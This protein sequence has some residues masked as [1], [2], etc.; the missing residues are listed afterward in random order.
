MI[1]MQDKER[2][3]VE[4]SLWHVSQFLQRMHP[5]SSSQAVVARDLQFQQNRAETPKL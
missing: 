1:T 5:I 2:N 3:S 4:L